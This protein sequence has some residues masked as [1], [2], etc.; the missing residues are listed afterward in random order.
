MLNV[1][2]DSPGA[3]QDLLLSEAPRFLMVVF[4]VNFTQESENIFFIIIQV[5][6]SHK[7]HF[8]VR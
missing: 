8:K 4:N 5:D 3:R 1:A 6:P 2:T 7:I